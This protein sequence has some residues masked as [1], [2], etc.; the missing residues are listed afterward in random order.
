[1]SDLS[2]P[3]AERECARLKLELL[4]R[5]CEAERLNTVIVGLKQRVKSEFE[6][7]DQAVA[8]L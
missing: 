8:L 3:H 5:S 1:M 7:K 2:Q 4:E 6:D